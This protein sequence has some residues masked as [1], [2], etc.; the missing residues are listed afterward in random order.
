MS[1]KPFDVLSLPIAPLI[2]SPCIDLNIYFETLLSKKYSQIRGS[3][4]TSVLL[5]KSLLMEQRKLFIH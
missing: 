3:Y 5:A 4:S 1:P 2:C